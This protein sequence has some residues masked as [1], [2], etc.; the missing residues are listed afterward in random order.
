M[1]RT[2]IPVDDDTRETLET[3]EREDETLDDFLLRVAGD[4]DAI[5]F[6]S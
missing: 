4:D 2:S 6:G 1:G 3:R 5:E